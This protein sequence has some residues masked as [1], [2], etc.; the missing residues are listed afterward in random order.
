MAIFVGSGGVIYDRSRKLARSTPFGWHQWHV[1]ALTVVEM[2]ALLGARLK[3]DREWSEILG[4]LAWCAQLARKVFASIDDGLVVPD[5]KG[6]PARDHLAV[7]RWSARR[8]TDDADRL[9]LAGGAG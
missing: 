2:S 8:L 6:E 3:Q 4:Q 7:L 9:N 1:G 5:G